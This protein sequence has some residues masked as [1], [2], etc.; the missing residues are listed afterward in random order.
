MP[1]DISIYISHMSVSVSLLH[2]HIH[3]Y[4]YTERQP[5]RAQKQEGGGEGDRK[6]RITVNAWSASGCSW[7]DPRLLPHPAGSDGMP[8][9]RPACAGNCWWIQQNNR[10]TGIYQSRT[11]NPLLGPLQADPAPWPRLGVGTG[12]KWVLSGRGRSVLG[13]RGVWR[14]V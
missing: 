6:T 12:P 7:G 14:R 10:V 1:I 3:I 9:R 13:T 8:A 2:T 11:G 5:E 4:I